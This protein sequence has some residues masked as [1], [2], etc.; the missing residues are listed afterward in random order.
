MVIFLKRK[1]QFFNSSDICLECIQCVVDARYVM[2]AG[3][4]KKERTKDLSVKDNK[5]VA[6][7]WQKCG[8]S[9]QNKYVTLLT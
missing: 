6:K 2:M 3:R 8:M 1:M 5:A 4:N 9:S 7:L